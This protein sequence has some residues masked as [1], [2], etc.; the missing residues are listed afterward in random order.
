MDITKI[1]LLTVKETV[2]VAEFGENGKKTGSH[3][4]QKIS[5][6]SFDPINCEIEVKEADGTGITVGIDPKII[7]SFI[8]WIDGKIERANAREQ[9]RMAREAAIDA[10][11]LREAEARAHEAE[12]SLE[13][14]QLRHEIRMTEL[15]IE[16]A[17]RRKE[18]AEA[19]AEVPA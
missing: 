18:L 12:L 11:R 17:Q 9:E 15:R 8:G 14:T 4:E 3:L 2:K 19:E 7:N 13:E 16:L 5:S 1:N 10:Q 6:A